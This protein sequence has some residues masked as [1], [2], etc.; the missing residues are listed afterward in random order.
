MKN[1]N[2]VRPLLSGPA[3]LSADYGG[4]R[5]QMRPFPDAN[6]AGAGRLAMARRSKR[7]G[8]DFSA[9]REARSAGILGPMQQTAECVDSQRH[10]PRGAPTA[11]TKGEL[12][13]ILSL[14]GQFVA[15]GEWRDYAVD[16]KRDAA[17]FSIFR[18]AAEVPVYRIEKQPRLAQRQGVYCVV[19][20]SGAILKRGH[21]LAQVLRIFDR[22]KLRL[23]AL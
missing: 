9:C 7:A 17:I 16:H 20:M 21:D 1:R 4:A 23:A 10:A 2:S 13:L 8:A 18:R 3:K 15:A 19:S 12:A 14:Y 5:D 22:Q 11:F 6:T